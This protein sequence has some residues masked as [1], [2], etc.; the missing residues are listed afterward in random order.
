MV[1]NDVSLRQFLRTLKHDLRADTNLA[2]TER[3]LD[4]WT[5][6]ACQALYFE[7]RDLVELA[8]KLLH[9][10][11]VALPVAGAEL[12]EKRLAVVIRLYALGSL[13]MRLIY[14]VVRLTM[15]EAF[16]FGG[17][18]WGPPP[19]VQAFLTAKGQQEV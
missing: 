14:N 11:Y 18:W 12:T 9:E 8:I 3:A 5:I 2:E 13:A 16:K 17:R 1:S 4:K 7:R 19:S 15:Q 10:A 6:I